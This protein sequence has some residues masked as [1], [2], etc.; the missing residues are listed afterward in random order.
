MEVRR[1]TNLGSPT[2]PAIPNRFGKGLALFGAACP[3]PAARAL[4]S[5][6]VR[7]SPAPSGRCKGVAVLFVQYP[8][9]SG[10]PSGKRDGFQGAAF[11]L[12]LGAGGW[13][14][15]SVD[16]QQQIAIVRAKNRAFNISC[17]ILPRPS[18][19]LQKQPCGRQLVCTADF[20]HQSYTIRTRR[21]TPIAGIFP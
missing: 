9:R 6:A 17:S 21:E 5:S 7:N 2:P 1:M 8:C 4:T 11:A 14:A 18:F 3:P 13:P 12:P 20:Q 19:I 15:A 16:A 10:C